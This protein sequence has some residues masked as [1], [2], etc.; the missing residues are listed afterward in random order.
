MGAGYP[1]LAVKFQGMPAQT[2]QTVPRMRDL[3]DRHF[4]VLVIGGGITGCGVA[5]DAAMR[6]LSVALVERDDFA[7]GTSGRSSRLVH[8]GIRYLEQGRFHLVHE[9]IR[10]R[11]TLL[12]IAPHIVKPLAFTWPIYRGARIGRLKLGAG[13]ILYQLLAL[14]RSHRPSFLGAGKTLDREPSLQSADLKGGAVYFDAATDDSRLT[15]ATAMSAVE[16]GAVV[17][18]HTRVTRILHEGDRAIGAEVKSQHSTEVGEIRARVIV[19]ATGVWQNAAG[20]IERGPRS[21]GSKGVHIAVPNQRVGNRD[22]ITMISSVDG[23]VMF[24][25]PAGPHTII[26]TTDTW[27]DESP[28][29]VHASTT[30]V[31]YLLRSA[32]SYFP[33]A[34]LTFDDVISAWAG[35][36]PLVAT[37]SNNPSAASREHSILADNS[38]VIRVT[39]GKL[40]TYRAM[41]AEVVDRVQEALGQRIR[42]APTDRVVLPGADRDQQIARLSQHDPQLAGTLVEGLPYTGGQLVYS[43]QREMAKTLSD[44]LIRRTHIAFQTRDH[45]RMVAP[46][47][48]DIVGPVLGWDETTK[49]ARI[50]EFNADVEHVFAIT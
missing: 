37:Q 10:E 29:N 42:P 45:G 43:V 8:G 13:L 49:R 50:N 40:T 39:G 36:R 34:K 35:I 46:H 20:S 15:V 17:V 38:G 30:D 31:D 25:L 23:R 16:S 1:N 41:A 19:N 12:R 11:Q 48:A 18:T 27:T 21:R 33:R 47:A 28:E 26:G 2:V 32:N 7:S 14:G 44:L 5:R 22:A 6:G 9:S 3:F 4:D 24:C